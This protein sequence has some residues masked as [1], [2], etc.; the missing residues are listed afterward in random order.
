MF[1]N[2]REIKPVAWISE[3]FAYSRKFLN[4]KEVPNVDFMSHANISSD[5]VCKHEDGGLY[6]I[7]QRNSEVIVTRLLHEV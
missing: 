6:A 7:F 4:Q 1:R 5:G 3:L 2:E